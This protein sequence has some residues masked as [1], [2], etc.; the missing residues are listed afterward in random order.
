MARCSAQP[1]EDVGPVDPAV[2]E[3]TLDVLVDE[4]TRRLM[5]LSTSIALQG[6]SVDL[7]ATLSDHD[8]EFDLVPPS[9]DQVIESNATGATP[10]PM[11]PGV[12]LD[13]VGNEFE[14]S[15]YGGPRDPCSRARVPL[16]AALGDC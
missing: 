16:G 13:E 5:S 10:A 1:G 9:S 2:P 8:V 4:A 12:I 11:A 7:T 3:I 14:P 15:P 6:Q